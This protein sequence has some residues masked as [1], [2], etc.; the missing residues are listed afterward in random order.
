[1]VGTVEGAV[2]G[3]AGVGVGSG[4]AAWQRVVS[5]RWMGRKTGAGAGGLRTLVRNGAVPGGGAGSAGGTR[6]VKVALIR[7]LL[8]TDYL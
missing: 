4:A 2:S 1:M 7:W 6:G 3:A 5:V 8:V